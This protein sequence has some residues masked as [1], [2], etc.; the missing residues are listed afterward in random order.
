MHR[1]L[2]FFLVL[3][4]LVSTAARSGEAKPVAFHD[5]YYEGDDITARAPLP[6]GH[7]RN[8]ILG[9]FH[10]DPSFCRV[11]DDYYLVN[12]SF[13][14]FPGLPIFHSQDLVNW[15]P[16]GNAIDRPTQLNYDDVGVSQG[17]YAPA[18]T[19]RDGTFYIICTMV[20]S[21]MAPGW[22]VNFIISA[23]NPA[24]PWSD[25]TPLPF[26]GM[27]PALFF[28]DDGRAYIVNNGSPEGGSQ[29]PGHAAIWLQ[30]FDLKST[31]MVGPRTMIVNGGVDL[32]K[33]PW[34]IEGPHL[35]KR[36]DHYYLMC[37]EG[38]TEYNHSE[39]V[40]RSDTVSG[41][42]KP[43]NQNPILTQRDLSPNVPGA[44]VSAGHADIARGPDGKDW[45]VFLACRPYE[46]TRYV[47]GRETFMLPVHWTNDDW[48]VILPAGQRV[49]L[50]VP[51]PKAV[52]IN[53]ANP[54]PLNGNF[55]WKDSFD[56][57]RLNPEW[58][59]IRQPHQTWLHIRNHTL[60]LTP[61]TASLA[62]D[63]QPAFIARRVQHSRFTA[64]ATIAIPS[65]ANTSAGLA[66]F[67]NEKHFYFLGVHGSAHPTLFLE[68]T[69]GD[70][71]PAELA[72]TKLS[73]A[74]EIH[75]QLRVIDGSIEAS[76]S[77]DG[78]TW[79]RLGSKADA[80][81]LTTEVAGGFVGAML[82]LYARL[83]PTSTP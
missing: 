24:G 73:A 21:H 25:P 55:T 64:R 74:G 36:K 62:L 63:G 53:P 82:G 41:P 31:R 60:W 43:W 39:V 29:Y 23:K 6:A 9:G 57:A 72:S 11:G 42:Y 27:D 75:L 58:L 10:P 33:T 80:S 28:D 76:F 19:Y 50:I 67:Q 68:Q 81:I 20:G 16:L 2:P 4:A 71:H 79:Q 26:E 35:F 17:I 46:R 8:P 15:T 65:E 37:A 69:K 22:S 3:L 49:P 54:H 77:Q 56:S 47:T 70:T 12:S 66:V 44:V 61:Q 7:Y 18:I 5:F 38:G 34:Y 32:A 45:A 30:E 59:M 78:T 83:D 40:F 51:S 48:P 1:P 13:I 14:Y 52:S